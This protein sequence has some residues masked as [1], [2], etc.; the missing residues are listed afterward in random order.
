MLTVVRSG[1]RFVTAP[2]RW[3]WVTLLGIRGRILRPM[4]KA[5]LLLITLAVVIC[6]PIVVTDIDGPMVV[7]LLTDSA[8]SVRQ[9]P[10]SE[11][12]S[13]RTFEME[14]DGQKRVVVMMTDSADSL[15]LDPK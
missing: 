5:T 7:V 9:S 4:R 13:W 2:R 11:T 1:Y 6:N 15:R 3:Y 14:I 12:E 8:D 10:L